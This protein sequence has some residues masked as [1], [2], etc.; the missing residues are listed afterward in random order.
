M[1]FLEEC[2]LSTVEISISKDIV[3]Q[4]HV[5]F[6]VAE[7]PLSAYTQLSF[8]RGDQTSNKRPSS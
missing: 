2:S 5:F 4:N 7:M 1:A 3:V 8:L 6:T